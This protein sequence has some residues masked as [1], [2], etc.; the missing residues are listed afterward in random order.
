[1]PQKFSEIGEENRSGQTLQNK[2][3]KVNISKSGKN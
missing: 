3:I 1:M 2:E